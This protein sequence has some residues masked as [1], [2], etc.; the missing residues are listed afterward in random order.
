MNQVS[1]LIN[2]NLFFQ[3]IDEDGAIERLFIK[4]KIILQMYIYHCAVYYW[5]RY[6]E[7]KTNTITVL[8]GIYK[9]PNL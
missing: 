8:Y 4:G 1:R 2:A 9:T 6:V 3:V 5:Y 7:K